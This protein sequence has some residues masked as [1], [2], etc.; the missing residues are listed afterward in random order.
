M[1]ELV[2]IAAARERAVA[3]LL[4]LHGLSGLPVALRLDRAQAVGGQV[5]GAFKGRRVQPSRAAGGISGG[6][7]SVR[8]GGVG[9]G[10][11]VAQRTA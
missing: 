4:I 6:G 2:V 8:V 10:G 1:E 7:S 3:R 9:D 11:E 5:V